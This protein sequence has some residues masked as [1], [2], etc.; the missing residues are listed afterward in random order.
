VR[1]GPF[2]VTVRAFRIM[3][4][5]GSV[6]TCSREENAELFRLALGGYGLFGIILDVDLAMADN[7]LLERRQELFDASRFGERFSA[8][9]GDPSVRM[10][11]GRLSIA[12]ENF[13]QEALLVA[14]RPTSVQPARLPPAQAPSS[15]VFVSRKLFR[16]QVGS[17][18]GKKARWYAETVLLP[19]VAT[20][21]ITRNTILNYPV[22]AIAGDHPDETDI[23]HEYFV[24][25]ERFA[26]FLAA[27]RETIPAFKQDLLNVT[28]RY[29]DSDPDSVLAYAPA[30]RIAAVMLF[31]HPTTTSADDAMRRM[32]ERLI[33]QVLA[34][35]GSF[36][37]PYRL[38]ARPDQIR[39]AYPRLDDMIA[40]KRHYDPR[41]RFRNLM[42]DKYFA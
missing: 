14:Y 17:E 36:Y 23:L 16:A 38:H 42:W 34:L 11:Y 1:H 29:V 8:V 30:P 35:G 41:L 21:P 12:Q 3:L 24:A 4:A 22:S 9:A 13:L 28:L 39:A 27:C 7:V 6:L 20:K 26:E 15:Y 5:D 33:D 32:T 31:V 37:L 25:P 2:G 40:R 19:R 18:R 10:A